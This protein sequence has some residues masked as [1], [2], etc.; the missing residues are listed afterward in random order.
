MVGGGDV[1]ASLVVGGG[2]VG[3]GGVGLKGVLR[4]DLKGWERV[5]VAVLRRRRL[6]GWM[7]D[8]GST[9]DG[10]LGGRKL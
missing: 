9:C 7:G 5:F 8:I 4:G 6:E 3:G 2:G 1:G 10:E